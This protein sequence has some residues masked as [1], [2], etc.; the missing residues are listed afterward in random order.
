MEFPKGIE[1]TGSAIIENEKG[2]ILI[3][4]SPKWPNKWLLPG[5]HVDPGE[6]I[7][8]AQKREAEEETGLS[9][10]AV[11]IISFGELINS[12]DFYRPAHFIYFDVLGIIIEKGILWTNLNQFQLKLRTRT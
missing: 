5:G 1:I 10:K 11:D 4:K 9:L 3:V 7:M 12:K 8:D 6:T 2:E